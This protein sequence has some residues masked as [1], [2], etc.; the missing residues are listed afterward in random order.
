M[1]QNNDSLNGTEDLENIISSPSKNVNK[2]LSI[3]EECKFGKV[4][5]EIDSV[6]TLANQLGND[7]RY[8]NFET[9]EVGSV[10]LTCQLH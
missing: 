9:G 4:E 6:Y 10:S 2:E 3:D 1:T 8:Y 5:K 7:D